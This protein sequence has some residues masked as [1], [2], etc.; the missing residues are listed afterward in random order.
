[1][2]F[3]SNQYNRFF[4]FAN[5]EHCLNYPVNPKSNYFIM[6]FFLHIG[7]IAKKCLHLLCFE[8]ILKCVLLR[9]KG[10][11][12][13]LSNKSVVLQSHIQ[14]YYILLYFLEVRGQNLYIRGTY[15]FSGIMQ[16]LSFELK[17]SVLNLFYGL[18]KYLTLK[19]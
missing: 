13:H 2:S 4:I 6:F 14:R 7:F 1:M 3:L 17:K 10:Y 12:L 15:T 5:M 16:F 8:S 9:I 19:T 18:Y 11:Y